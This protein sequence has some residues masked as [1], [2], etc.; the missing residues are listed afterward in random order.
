[1]DPHFSFRLGPLQ[2]DIPFLYVDAQQPWVQKPLFNEET[3]LTGNEA[4]LVPFRHALG[5]V[6]LAGSP[7]TRLVQI[8]GETVRE[9]F[10]EQKEALVQKI[11]SLAYGFE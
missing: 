8:D 1:M 2:E 7:E 10:A 4:A 9:G 5:F 3:A 11:Q 6:G